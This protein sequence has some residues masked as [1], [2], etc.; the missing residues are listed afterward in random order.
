MRAIVAVTLS[1]LLTGC[2][3][4]NDYA[5]IQP[6]RMQTKASPLS[7][8][9]LT[10]EDLRASTDVGS[11]KNILGMKTGRIL[12]KTPIATTLYESL[13]HRL[14]S[15]GVA[16]EASPLKL[17]VDIKR[18][19]SEYTTGLFITKVKAQVTLSIKLLSSGEA[20]LYEGDIQGKGILSPVFL[21]SGKNTAK[22]ISLALQQTLDKLCDEILPLVTTR[23]EKSP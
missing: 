11:I 9:S 14:A 12:P 10:V 21:Y 1:F 4:R 18:C 16:V 5:Y 15:Y 3:I 22:A 7:T 13:A 23:K 20:L 8:L 6:E 2:A 17:S 19:Y